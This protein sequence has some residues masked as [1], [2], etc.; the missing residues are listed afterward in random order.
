MKQ[1]AIIVLAGA[2][3]LPPLSVAA[4][5]STDSRAKP[6]SIVPHAHSNSHVY[7]TPIQPA[8]VSHSRT[9]HH[10]LTPKKKPFNP[11]K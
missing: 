2:L 7:G 1:F 6:S 4:D 5:K 8:I 9:H 11:K 3:M 10:K